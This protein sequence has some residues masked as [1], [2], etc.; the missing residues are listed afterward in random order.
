MRPTVL[1]IDD[2]PTFCLMLKSFLTKKDFATETAFSGAEALN[3]VRKQDFDVVLS[4]FRLPDTDGLELLE[5]IRE[6]KP[7][8]PVIIMTSYADIRIAVKAMKIGAY[9]Y[10]TKPVNPDEIL[11]IVRNALNRE[12]EKEAMPAAIP[13]SKPQQQSGN[14]KNP[15]KNGFEYVEGNSVVAKRIM[16]YIDVVAPTNLS[17]IIH[18]ESGTGKEYVAKMIHQKSNRS[19]KPF[20]S[21]DCGALSK[22]LAASELFGHIKGSFTGAIVDKTGQFVFAE[23]GTLFLDEIGNLT[24]E[25]QVQLLRAIQERRIRK[26]GSNQDVEVDVRIIVATNEDLQDAVK[27]GNFRE[28]L[29]HRLNEFKIIVPS[30]RDREDDINIFAEHF[31]Q[32]ANAELNKDVV[33]FDDEVKAIFRRYS[34]PG[35]LRELRNV[36]RRA[37]LLTSG[38]YVRKETLPHEIVFEKREDVSNNQSVRTENKMQADQPLDLKSLAEKTERELI[39]N[40]LIK[41]NYNKSK[42]A[43]LL[44]IDRKTLYNKMKLYKILTDD[45]S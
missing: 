24:Y 19:H 28:D 36:V 18:G 11:L 31:L 42:A 6:I 40:T 37:V 32:L 43:A 14:K 45:E 39:I 2:D 17:V 27:K 29:Y 20:V 10:V 5:N 44:K 25:I 38:E 22:E 1:I 35:N 33:N 34:W 12:K 21:I 30:L 8:T 15:P 3:Q 23:G 7:G 9:E 4:D 26:I 41:V 13:A 16:E